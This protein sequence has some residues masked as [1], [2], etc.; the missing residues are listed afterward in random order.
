L[1]DGVPNPFFYNVDF[2]NK[3]TG[4]AEK[5]VTTILQIQENYTI[6]KGAECECRWGIRPEPGFLNY[7]DITDDFATNHSMWIG[8]GSKLFARLSRPPQTAEELQSAIVFLF[9]SYCSNYQAKPNTFGSRFES[10]KSRM[11][12]GDSITEN[13]LQHAS[14]RK[15]GPFILFLGHVFDFVLSTRTGKSLPGFPQH[16]YSRSFLAYRL[17]YWVMNAMQER[18]SGKLANQ[19]YKLWFET[20]KPSKME[21]MK[22]EAPVFGK[23]G[24]MTMSFQVTSDSGEESESD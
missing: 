17:T 11:L 6:S 4:I 16:L 12:A 22:L 24:Q 2:S 7:H 1:E 15:P 18:R 19:S 8:N 21:K 5:D 23:F 10:L 3:V 13:E 9:V 20:L 14:L